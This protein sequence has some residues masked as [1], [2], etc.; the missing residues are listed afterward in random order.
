[1]S[2]E[3]KLMGEVQLIVLQNSPSVGLINN[4]RVDRENPGS[5]YLGACLNIW[6]YYYYILY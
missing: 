4:S 2:D 3:V 6:L 1:M 5:K